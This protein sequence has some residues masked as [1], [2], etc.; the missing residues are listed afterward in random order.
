MRSL[1]RRQLQYGIQWGTL[2]FVVGIGIVWATLPADLKQ[3]SVETWRITTW[4][5][6]NAHGIGIAGSQVGGFSMAPKTVGFIQPNPKLHLLRILPLFLVTICGLLVNASMGGAHRDWHI[7]EN[8]LVATGGYVLTGLGAVLVSE[9]RPGIT[10]I[11]FIIGVLGAALYSGALIARK[12][13]IQ[14]FAVT[15]MSSLVGVG[16]VAFVGIG[17]LSTVVIPLV[18]SVVGGMIVATVSLWLVNNFSWVGSR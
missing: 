16:L 9:A 1:R 10:M 15:T 7:L 3:A 11:L 4:V 13:P 8:T 18:K 5:W 6:V 17:V 14:A 2:A 12:L